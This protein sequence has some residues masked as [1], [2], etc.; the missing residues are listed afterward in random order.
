MK[1]TDPS[2]PLQGGHPFEIC[3][4]TI[5][6]INYEH[7]I[8]FPLLEENRYNASI[9]RTRNGNYS[10][11]QYPF[12]CKAIPQ[13]FMCF[14]VGAN[15]LCCTIFEK[16]VM[17]GTRKYTCGMGMFGIVP[18]QWWVIGYYFG[19]LPIVLEQILFDVQRIGTIFELRAYQHLLLC[20]CPIAAQ[21]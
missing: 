20:H 16:L 9:T 19:D 1:P 15:G 11:T 7:K 13:L 3:A 6:N 21:R 14:G 2:S 8:C 18:N 17:G 12:I 10:T 5:W 4:I